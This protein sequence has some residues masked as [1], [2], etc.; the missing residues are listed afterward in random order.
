M[1]HVSKGFSHP[2]TCSISFL[3]SS[4][5]FSIFL[6]FNKIKG[7]CYPS[8]I[9]FIIIFI[10]ILLRKINNEGNHRYEN[11]SYSIKHAWFDFIFKIFI[12]N[13]LKNFNYIE[14]NIFIND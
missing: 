3:F 1:G 12:K 10:F 11:F 13:V 14:I 6:L 9:T 8:L 7:N 4:S 5:F 2:I